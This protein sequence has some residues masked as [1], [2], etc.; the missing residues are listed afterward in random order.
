MSEKAKRDAKVAKMLATRKQL[1][2]EYN[3]FK[4]EQFNH[5]MNP[6]DDAYDKALETLNALKND[7]ET[8]A[9]IAKK[10]IAEA[11]NSET[12][13][14]IKM[15]HAVNLQIAKHQINEATAMFKKIDNEYM[16]KLH[17]LGKED[18]KLLA[19][20]YKAD[21]AYKKALDDRKMLL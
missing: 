8:K 3:Q 20:C 16:T 21:E 2:K 10:Q 19:K 9:K 14:Q 6:L 5:I 4:E 12:L 7:Y 1:W 11:K 15:E 17:H 18:R 13:S